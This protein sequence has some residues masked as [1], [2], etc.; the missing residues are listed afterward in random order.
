MMTIE[1][2]TILNYTSG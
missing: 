1:N 2:E